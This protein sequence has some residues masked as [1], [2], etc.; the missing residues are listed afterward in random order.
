MATTSMQVDSETRDQLAAIAERDFE[1]ASLGDALRRLVREH[2]INRIVR[3]YEDLRADADEWASY[4]D[5]ARLTDNVAG[6]ALPAA[7][8]EYPEYNS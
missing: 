7:G 5:E 6:D 1:G 3:R 8:D 4:R 2:Q